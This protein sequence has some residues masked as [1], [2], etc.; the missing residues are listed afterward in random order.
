MIFMQYCLFLL[1]NFTLAA[2]KSAP[3]TYL[4]STTT[5]SWLEPSFTPASPTDCLI[6]STAGK[7]KLFPGV[8]KR[9]SAPE[10]V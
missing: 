8:I 5:G 4:Q 7:Y 1:Q 9:Y 6:K 3:R 2:V 10:S